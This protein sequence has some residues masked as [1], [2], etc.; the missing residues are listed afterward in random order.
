M[1]GPFLVRR[2]LG[3][4]QVLTDAT[5]DKAL[6]APRAVIYF[7]SPSCPY[8]VAYKPV[9]EEVAREQ[10]GK[11]LMASLD[12]NDAKASATKYN[13]EG[14][15]ATI[16][17][18]NG[19]EV[20]RVEGGLNKEDLQAQISKVFGTAAPAASAAS[21]LGLVLGGLVLVAGGIYLLTRKG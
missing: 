17:L 5:L 21:P 13:I 14:I 4:A 7:G 9:F 15:P 6:S 16:F 20:G 3:Q 10:A 2:R 8:C 12:A 11:I 19:Q 18:V 1:S